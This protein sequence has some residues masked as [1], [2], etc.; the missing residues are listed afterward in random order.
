MAKSKLYRLMP[1]S[2]ARPFVEIV[3]GSKVFRDHQIC[4]Y[5]IS[6]GNAN[7]NLDAEVPTCSITILGDQPLQYNANVAVNVIVPL[8]GRIRRF[9]G[10]VGAQEKKMLGGRKYTTTFLCTA[11]SIG[12]FRSSAKYVFNGQT[13]R[14]HLY[15]AVQWLINQ[16]RGYS[17][18]SVEGAVTPGVLEAM[19]F[20]DRAKEW[21]VSDLLGLLSKNATGCFHK[22]DGRIQFAH[23]EFMEHMAA[24]ATVNMKPILKREALVPATVAQ[25]K[26]YIDTRHKVKAYEAWAADELRTFDWT[27]EFA[28]RGARLTNTEIL[29]LS[30]LVYDRGLW[31]YGYRA[32]MLREYELKFVI[33]EL[34]FSMPLLLRGKEYDSEVFHQI[35]KLEE[36][37]FIATGADWG[38]VEALMICKGYTEKMTPDGWEIS[39]NLIDPRHL[40]GFSEWRKPLPKPAAYTWTQASLLQTWANTPQEM[41]W[42]KALNGY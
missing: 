32:H 21:S 34:S 4:E 3:I 29:D 36:G 7:A 23:T 27:N 16:S 38:E 42:K 10:R 25:D 35:L 9:T 19:R 24:R 31:N 14:N 41:T 2:F 12:L 5:T 40:F 1:A 8:L 22:K 13:G 26:S 11:S 6:Y 37:D 28:P 18:L 33:K 39:I 15:D 30:D 20:K 17:G